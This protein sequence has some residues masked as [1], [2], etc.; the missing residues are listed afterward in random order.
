M[1]DA[2]NCPQCGQRVGQTADGKIVEHQ[3]PAPSRERCSGSGQ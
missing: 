2:T 3:K 1:A